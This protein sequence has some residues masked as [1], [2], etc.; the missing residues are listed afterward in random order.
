MPHFTFSTRYLGT[1]SCGGYYERGLHGLI[2]AYLCGPLQKYAEE[3]CGCG[4]YNPDCISD[5]SKCFTPSEH[6]ST[7]TQPGHHDPVESPP[8]ATNAFGLIVGICGALLGAG[9][10]YAYIRVD[11][12]PAPQYSTPDESAVVDPPPLA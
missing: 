9:I 8:E 2:P 6:T 3:H 1:Y 4:G 11:R 10:A 5:P 7:A 12:V